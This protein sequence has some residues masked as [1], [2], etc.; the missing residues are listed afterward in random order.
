MPRTQDGRKDMHITGSKRDC[1]CAGGAGAE[2][3]PVLIK[4]SVRGSLR[5]L[6]HAETLRVFQRGCARAGVKIQ[7]TEGFNPHPKL[8]LSLPRTVGVESEDD[9]VQLKVHTKRRTENQSEASTL[10]LDC[11]QL[12]K[13]LSEQLP[14]GCQLLTVSLPKDK[15]PLQPRSA[16]Y[17]LP[18]KKEH[19]NE[20]LRTAIKRLLESESLSL[21][22]WR[23]EKRTW[24]RQA[25]HKKSK[26]VD[27]RGFLK[28]IRVSEEAVIVECKISSAGSIRVDEILRLLE[29]DPEKLA[30]PI[31]RTA[32]EWQSN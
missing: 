17:I 27:V 13:K 20:K 10:P 6:S 32:V 1:D 16:T 31:R 15:A 29:L 14:Q 21:Q 24:I 18:V 8:S 19:I 2:S 11:D 3:V 12:K 26:I 25:H 30:G 28:S 22:R 23:D 9:L 7:Y 4:F 5:F